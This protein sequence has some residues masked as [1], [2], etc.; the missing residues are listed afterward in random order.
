MPTV[1]V[2]ERQRFQRR[3][4]CRLLRAAG[5]DRVVDAV[6]LHAATRV[7]AEHETASWMIVADPDAIGAD[8]VTALSSLDYGEV[9]I[10]F[11]LLCNRRGDALEHLRAEAKSHRMNL[12]AALRKPV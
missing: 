2:I 4:L 11:L 5:A 8:G 1:L 12:V 10:V 6:D 3:A 9:S 7:I